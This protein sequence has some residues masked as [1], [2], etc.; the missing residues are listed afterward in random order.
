VRSFQRAY[1]EACRTGKLS[2]EFVA[3]AVANGLYDPGAVF[4]IFRKSIGG[5]ARQR[6]T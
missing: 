2:P 4:L 6:P 3:F 1:G 5:A